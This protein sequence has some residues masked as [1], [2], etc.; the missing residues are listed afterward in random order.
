MDFALA[1]LPWKLL[2]GLT[3]KKK[4]RIGAALAM[5]MGVLAG[6]TAVIKTINLPRLTS[7][8]GCKFDAVVQRFGLDWANEP[9]GQTI[10]LSFS[11][12]TRPREQ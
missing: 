7:A 12:G 4:E 9:A 10:P 6:I 8:D 5:S 2:S 1:L 11:S 3:M